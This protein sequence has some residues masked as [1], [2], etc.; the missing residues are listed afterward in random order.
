MVADHQGGEHQGE[1]V[2]PRRQCQVS[3]SR[4]G[5]ATDQFAQPKQATF[6]SPL[7]PAAAGNIPHSARLAIVPAR[8]PPAKWVA[9]RFF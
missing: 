8:L 6:H 5:R 2:R 3:H 7:V 9:D 1:L 4:H